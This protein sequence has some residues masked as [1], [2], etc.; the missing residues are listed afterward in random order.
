M[1]AGSRL[2]VR[3]VNGA[4]SAYA[5]VVGQPKDRFTVSGFGKPGSPRG[6]VERNGR[7]LTLCQAV[8]KRGSKCLRDG[9]GLSAPLA[10][11]LRVP[12]RVFLDVRTLRGAINISDVT[13]NVL[14]RAEDGNVKI[15]IEGYANAS[16]RKGNVS[17]TFG[18]TNWPG[19]L[20]FSA[21]SGDVE[22]YVNAKAAAR[23][24]L[25]TDRGTIFT[26]FELRGTA[27]GD[28][29][30]IDGR[31]GGGGDHA[32]DVAV[33]NGSIRMLQLKPQV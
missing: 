7:D 33:H 17:V 32:I 16:A 15:M 27:H 28:S 8:P 13:G 14:A 5:P 19:T 2:T 1:E 9:A 10:F 4:V 11:L 21:E 3:A 29:E 25:H 20:H 23:V 12:D 6:L 30:T 22:I 26:D 24:H 18:S 31:I